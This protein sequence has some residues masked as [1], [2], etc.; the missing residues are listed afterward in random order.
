MGIICRIQEGTTIRPE[1][2]NL[3]VEK[4]V[5]VCRIRDNFECRPITHL[6]HAN[7]IAECS[8]FG[9]FIDVYR[10]VFALGPLIYRASGFRIFYDDISTSGECLDSRWLS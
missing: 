2:D 4:S 9:T 6:F 5:Q 1:F 7:R 8:R 10:A 3:P